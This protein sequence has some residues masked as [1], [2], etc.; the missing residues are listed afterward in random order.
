MAATS[1]VYVITSLQHLVRTLN[2]PIQLC[3]LGIPI[4]C[5]TKE[6]S[7]K[8]QHITKMHKI[9]VVPNFLASAHH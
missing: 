6:K 2:T 3:H 7:L 9:L 8:V 1:Y 4:F 5:L